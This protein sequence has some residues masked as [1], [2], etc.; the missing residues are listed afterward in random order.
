MTSPIYNTSKTVSYTLSN[1]TVNN[2]LD[3]GLVGDGYLGYGPV[4][5]TNLVKLLENFSN[6]TAPPNAIKGQLWYDSAKKLLK[7]YDG[8]FFSNVY[9]LP[10]D[11][12]VGNLTVDQDFVTANASVARLYTT[13]GIFWHANGNVYTGEAVAAGSDTQLQFNSGGILEGAY[14]LTTDGLNLTVGGTTTSQTANVGTVYISSNILWSNSVPYSTGIIVTP[15]GQSGSIQFNNGGEFAG[16]NGL[17]TN[18][19]SLYVT[20]PLRV[21]GID[22]PTTDGVNGQVL[23]TDGF[24]KLVWKT[25]NTGTLTGS[26]EVTQLASF[27]TNTSLQGTLEINT[28]GQDITMSNGTLTAQNLILTFGATGSITFPDGTTQ[29]TAAKFETGGV[30]GS[31]TTGQLAYF[32]TSNSLKSTAGITTNGSDMTINGTLSVAST[33]SA[34]IHAANKDYVD[35]ILVISK[36]YTDSKIAPLPRF[37]D[38]TA[39]LDPYAT[40]QFVL[41]QIGQIHLTGGTVGGTGSVNH[42][43]VWNSTSTLQNSGS[44]TTNGSDM[45]IGAGHLILPATPKDSTHATNKDYVDS[46]IQAALSGLTPAAAPVSSGISA[47]AGTAN[48]LAFYNTELSI[49]SSGI[50][51]NGN[52]ITINDLSANDVTANNVTFNDVT[53]SGI[54]RLNR[55][56]VSDLLYTDKLTVAGQWSEGVVGSLFAKITLGD[57]STNISRSYVSSPGTP[58]SMDFALSGSTFFSLKTSGMDPVNGSTKNVKILYPLVFPD[59]SVQTTA[60]ASAGTYS[61]PTASSS[62]LGGVKVDNTTIVINGNGVISA[63]TGGLP[64]AT[65][66]VLGG[67]KVDAT[68]INIDGTGVISARQYALPTAST[69]VLGGVKV[70]NSTI[71]ISSTGVISAATAGLPVASSTVLGGVKIG[72]G[73]TIN[74]GVLSTSINNLQISYP[75][76]IYAGETFSWGITGA[77]PNETW[78]A[79]TTASTVPRYPASAGSVVTLPASG[80]ATY[81][82]GSYGGATGDVTVIFNFSQSGVFV[83]RLTILNKSVSNVQKFTSSGTWTKPAGYSSTSRVLIQ[84]WGGGGHGGYVTGGGGGGYGEVWCSLGD[85]GSTQAVTIGAGGGV[86]QLSGGGPAGAGGPSSFWKVTATGGGGGYWGYGEAGSGQPG[87]GSEAGGVGA[88]GSQTDAGVDYVQAGNGWNGGGGGAGSSGTPFGTSVNGGAGGAFG[89]AG[90]VPG[91]GGGGGINSTLPGSGA[92]GQ[93]IVTVFP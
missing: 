61:L 27:N 32:K 34:G 26:G 90:S 81:S 83:K 44:I 4:I 75:S 87:A 2:E 25:I 41:D 86:G 22:Y 56:I 64:V 73:L 80:A 65:N 42:F 38:I 43:A 91:G 12:S 31:G 74:N 69:T 37:S 59:G 18:G 35:S 1:N 50:I 68:T 30:L 67:V 39:A 78:Y 21:S 79:T 20:G 85:L 77:K 62:T 70:D 48:R 19:S 10:N 36:S 52:N 13:T 82:D 88:Y 54:T 5:N 11:I 16:A 89:Q 33:P 55:T 92:S 9:T 51:V 15:K 72:S 93:T 23:S 47:A 29:N 49:K 46:A 76:T 7:I 3:I 84:V 6:T 40:K 71:T 45:T 66:T 28:N 24:G 53:A 57:D 8:G 60:A 14:G 58:D 17:I 63:A